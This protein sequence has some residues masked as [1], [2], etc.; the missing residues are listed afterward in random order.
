MGLAFLVVDETCPVLGDPGRPEETC[1]VHRGS[2]GSVEERN[3][4][5]EVAELHCTHF[6]ADR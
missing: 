5:S 2:Q 4:P 6:S 1:L 3:F